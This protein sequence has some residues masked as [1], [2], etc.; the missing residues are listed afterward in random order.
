MDMALRHLVGS[1]LFRQGVYRG[2]WEDDQSTGRGLPLLLLLELPVF[3]LVVP[4]VADLH[5]LLPKLPNNDLAERGIVDRLALLPF[6]DAP[7]LVDAH[8]TIP[9]EL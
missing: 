9:P 5:E 7:V 6:L 1:L 4:P 8:P 2:L 3:Q